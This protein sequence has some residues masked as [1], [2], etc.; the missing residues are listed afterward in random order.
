MRLPWLSADAD[1]RV[2]PPPERA[3]AE[4]PGLLA[5]GGALSPAWLMHAYRQGTFPWYSPGEPILWWC[6]D[7]RAVILPRE[8]RRHRSLVKAAR[9]RGYSVRRDTAFG[10]VVDGCAAPRSEGGGTWITAEMRAAYCALHALGVAHSVEVYD[11]DRLVGGLY[12]VRLGGVF[13]GESMYSRV[14]DASKIALLALADGAAAEGIEL[15]D[16]QFPTPHLE[17]LGARTLPRAEFLSRARALVGPPPA[18]PDAG[19]AP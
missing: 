11:G 16:C 5:A 1:P 10:A 18:A 7:P 13:F 6:P 19:F 17:R 9:N 8:F 12:G 4:P 3:L 14:A 15:I 2:L